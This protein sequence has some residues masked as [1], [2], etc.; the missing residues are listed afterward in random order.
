MPKISLRPN[1]YSKD[2]SPDRIFELEKMRLELEQIKA[3]KQLSGGNKLSADATKYVTIGFVII[4]IF[5]LISTLIIPTISK[6]LSDIQLTKNG[7]SMVGK[8]ILRKE[9]VQKALEFQH[10]EKLIS[11]SSMILGDA[12]FKD[13]GSGGINKDSQAALQKILSDYYNSQ[14]FIRKDTILK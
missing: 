6:A 3:D 4:I 10:T 1:D 13:P 5:L 7:Y 2:L 8:D 12:I 9:D 11:N 14:K